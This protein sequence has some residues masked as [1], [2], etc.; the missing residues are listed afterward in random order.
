MLVLAGVFSGLLTPA[1]FGADAERPVEKGTVRFQTVGDQKNIPDVTASR[2]HLRLSD[3]AK[4]KLPG[5]GV[6]IFQV[7]YPSP[8]VSAHPENNT[9]YS[10]Y[11]R[12][13]DRGRF[14]V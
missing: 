4:T 9:V 12:P 14:P 1:A 13:N 2:P 3:V 6:D 10:E 11:Y 5:G 7:R 8:V